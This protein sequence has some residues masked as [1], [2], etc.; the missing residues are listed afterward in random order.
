MY[1]VV[2]GLEV[3]AELNTISKNFSRAKNDNSGLPN[4]NTSVI[5][6]GFPGILPVANKEAFHKA[7]KIAIALNC[8]IPKMMMF[9]RKNYYYP[10]L[11][12][13]Y[14]I[15]QATEPI[16]KDGYVMINV[17]GV[18]KKVLINDVHLEEDTANL[19]HK[20]NYTLINYN[21]AGIPLLE[22][23]TKPCLYS[24][25][26]AIA[27]LECLRGIY[28][29]CNVSDCRNDLGEIRTDVNISLMKE[30]DQQL[31]TKV[32]MKNINSF[33]NVK[34]AIECEIN[35]Q[36]EILNNGEKVIQETRRFDEAT[37]KT[38]SL[39]TK[40][41]AIDYKYYIEPNIPPIKITENDI[42]LVKKE[43]PMLAND[44]IN[45]YISEFALSRY[46]ATILVKDRETAD[47]YEEVVAIGADK[48]NVAN[49]INGDINAYLSKNGLKIKDLY[50]KPEM[51]ALLLKKVDDNKLSIKQAKEILVKAL[52]EKKDPN[53]I[54]KAESITQID[55]DSEIREMVITILNNN[56]SLINDYR[57][58]RNVFDY[59]VGQVMKQTKGKANPSM[60]A[61]I[62][63]EEIEKR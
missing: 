34:L 25:E 13:G 12:K 36:T 11:P 44:R 47:F 23:V 1:K 49:W 21:R 35:R 24:S 17:N 50:L 43:I 18:D 56:N 14:Q 28:L 52:D 42:A 46:D 27:F 15:T 63:K 26:E 22:T 38:V 37:L 41:D 62:I 61:K 6:L 54:I 10:D 9:D 29:Y 33:N 8:S 5:D 19:T 2:I 7:L 40:V 45:K 48:K 59:F 55:N 32:E 16:G 58:G 51:L 4:T 60:T 30:E 3:H 39:R 53:E 31:G 57:N 20:D